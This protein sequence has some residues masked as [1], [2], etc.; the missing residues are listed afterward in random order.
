LE[1]VREGGGGRRVEAAVLVGAGVW[2]AGESQGLDCFFH[3]YFGPD[4][5]LFSI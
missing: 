2:P 4:C 1:A 5:F 3:F